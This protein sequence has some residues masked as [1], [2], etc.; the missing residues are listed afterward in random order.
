M[1]YGLE[2][3]LLLPVLAQIDVIEDFKDRMKPLAYLDAL[4]HMP[5]IAV[6]FGTDEAVFID[7]IFRLSDTNSAIIFNAKIGFSHSKDC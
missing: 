2:N 7:K 4:F 1:V 3:N 6:C 5:E